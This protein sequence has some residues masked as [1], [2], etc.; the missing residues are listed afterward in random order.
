M[1]TDNGYLGRFQQGQNVLI[2][3]SPTDDQGA[4]ATPDA[5]PTVVVTDPMSNVIVST[6]ATMLGDDQHF[7][8]KL[9]LGFN[10]D[11]FGRYSIESTFIVGE[12]TTNIS[13][14]FDMVGGG[15]GTGKVISM[16]SY[17]RP[18]AEYIVAQTE[19]GKLMHG[20]NPNV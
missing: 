18:D 15:D 8:L 1:P 12:V 4:P 10:F 5:T 19:G 20:K 13:G 7:G 2:L 3:V 6:K 16:M 17:S 11:N 14:L 9:F